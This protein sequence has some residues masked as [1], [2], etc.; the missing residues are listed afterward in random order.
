M[1]SIWGQRAKNVTG[2]ALPSGHYIAEE[3][4]DATMA[5]L[6]AFFSG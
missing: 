4:P 3:A 5:R 1:L 6:R 2:G